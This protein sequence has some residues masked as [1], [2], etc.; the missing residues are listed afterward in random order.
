MQKRRPYRTYSDDPAADYDSYCREQD[1][2]HD[3]L[4]MCIECDQHIEDEH[5]WDFGDGPLHEEC[6]ARLYRKRTEDVME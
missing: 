4:P 6:A 3:M 1:Y 5:V 2:L